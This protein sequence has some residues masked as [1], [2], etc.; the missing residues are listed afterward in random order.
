LIVKSNGGE[1][2][3]GAGPTTR[4]KSRYSID[5]N[6][7]VQSVR[8]SALSR[9][10]TLFVVVLRRKRIRIPSEKTV[11]RRVH[12]ETQAIHPLMDLVIKIS[13]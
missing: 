12:L 9:R 3:S 11:R 4:R 1:P 5:D 13:F 7:E 6:N 10:R 2:T 8:L